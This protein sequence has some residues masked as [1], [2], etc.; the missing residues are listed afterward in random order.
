MSALLLQI[1]LF[2]VLNYILNIF[3]RHLKIYK[4]LIAGPLASPKETVLTQ[5]TVY[6]HDTSNKQAYTVHAFE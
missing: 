1:N 6:G 2:Q 3:I 5:D 4:G